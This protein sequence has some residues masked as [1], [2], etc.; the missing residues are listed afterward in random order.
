[1]NK[2]T[3]EEL[4]HDMRVGVL[5]APRPLGAKNGY[6][7]VGIQNRKI[8]FIW[9]ELPNEVLRKLRVQ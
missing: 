2:D 1:M 4:V 5:E 9:E 3:K 7:R 6:W 8:S